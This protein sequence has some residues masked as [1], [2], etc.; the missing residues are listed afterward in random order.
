MFGRR[1]V[2]HRDAAVRLVVGTVAALAVAACVPAEDRSPAEV[3]TTAG[4]P[5]P[6]RP[7][8][9]ARAPPSHGPVR[10]HVRR[11]HGQAENSVLDGK[12]AR[13]GRVLDSRC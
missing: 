2:E 12:E 6:G 4:R 8:S 1:N 10:V 5:A 11:P 9:S 7:A 13:E 3:S